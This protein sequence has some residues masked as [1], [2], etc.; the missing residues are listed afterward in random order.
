MLIW[1]MSLQIHNTMLRGKD[2]Q[3]SF[4]EEEKLGDLPKVTELLKDERGI[5]A[6]VYHSP[7]PYLPVGHTA[8][9]PVSCPPFLES[10]LHVP[11]P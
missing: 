10:H 4:K 1:A 2:Y 8:S 5:K 6:Q 11:H 9:L 3:P 7:R